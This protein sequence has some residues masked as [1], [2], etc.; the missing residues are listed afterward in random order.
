MIVESGASKATWAVV[1][2]EKV[3][4]V[5]TAGINASVMAVKEMLA[6]A[7]KASELLEEQG[8]DIES[9]TDIRFYGAGL[10]SSESI[11][12]VDMV[13]RN[14]FPNATVACGTDLLAAAKAA[15]DHD[16]GI[17]AVLG[18]GS[19][20]GLY[21]GRKIVMNVRPGGFILGDEGGGCSLGKAFIA[22]WVKDLLPEG[23][24]SRFDEQFHLT[25]GSVVE[26]VYKGPS[27]SA[28]LASFAPFILSLEGDPYVDSLVEGN[29]RSF[30]E[31]SLSHYDLSAHE[32]SFVGS[33]GIACR[34][35]IRKVASHYGLR[36][37]CFIADPVDELIKNLLRE[38]RKNPRDLHD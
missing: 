28:W 29:I 3:T 34:E 14:V 33:F 21:N 18:T 31:R 17:V 32:V 10:V 26:S 11:L 1:D 38:R 15:F 12:T 20:S 16:E 24:R 9:V 5:R 19:N 36:V 13:L 4:Q 2:G 37:R 23:I 22:D 7:V 35:T 30:I 8:T 25:Y 27:P 6:V